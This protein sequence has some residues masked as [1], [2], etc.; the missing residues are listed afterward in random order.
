[1]DSAG[2]VGAARDTPVKYFAYMVGFGV[3]V[4]LFVVGTAWPDAVDQLLS[5][6]R[7]IFRAT[8]FR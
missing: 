4:T 5:F 6:M 3:L 2:T 7:A 1:M 8:I